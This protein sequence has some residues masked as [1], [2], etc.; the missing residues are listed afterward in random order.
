M[1]V[2]E[3]S[4][5]GWFAASRGSCS[6][7]VRTARNTGLTWLLAPLCVLALGL[8]PAV[9]PTW[10]Q[11]GEPAP[12][13]TPAPVPAPTPEPPASDSPGAT[14]VAQPQEP[15]APQPALESAAGQAAAALASSLQQAPSNVAIPVQVLSPG[16][17]GPVTQENISTA[18]ATAVNASQAP[19][20]TPAPADAAAQTTSAP[21]SA[22]AVAQSTQVSPSNVYIP[23]NIL[24]PGNSGPVTQINVSGAQAV[25]TNAEQAV[26]QAIPAAVGAAGAAAQVAAAAATSVQQAPSN[27]SAPVTIADVPVGDHPATQPWIWTWDWQ[28]DCSSSALP[29]ISAL[30]PIIAQVTGGA[31]QWH[32][33]WTCAPAPGHPSTPSVGATGSVSGAGATGDGSPSPASP[34]IPGQGSAPTTGASTT[35]PRSPASQARTH[36]ASSPEPFAG[37]GSGGMLAPVRLADPA[38]LALTA[39]DITTLSVISPASHMHS[40]PARAGGPAP[41]PRDPARPPGAPPGPAPAV[42]AAGTFGGSGPGPLSIGLVALIGAFCLSVPRLGARAQTQL[43]HRS[44][45]AVPERK[46]RPG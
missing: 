17:A 10:A 8:S 4:V 28:L 14:Q 6:A 40:A 2:W 1:H 44:A 18:D 19:T 9:A 36:R 26:Q 22:T 29:P 12:V 27:F 15:Q 33:T 24:S 20:A 45:Q 34:S 46:D 23:V 35:T 11:D 7:M 21:Q 30:G 39:G 16:N 37:L 31:W 3:I 41:T 5:H 38:D 13:P 42:F 43:V 32:W 25:A